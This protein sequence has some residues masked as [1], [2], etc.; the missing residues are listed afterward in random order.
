[1]VEVAS[2]LGLWGVMIGVGNFG[3]AN[4]CFV[5]SGL[6]FL[7][8]LV[9]V[10]NLFRPTKKGISC[11]LIGFLFV[12]LLVV[13]TIRWTNGKAGEADQQ[14]LQLARLNQLPDDLGRL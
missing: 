12:V 9:H 8:K 2:L 13:W 10:T 6:I 4:I 5:I 11:F 3:F 1:V 7:A 14:K